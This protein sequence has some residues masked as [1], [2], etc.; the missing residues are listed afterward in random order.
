ME[1]TLTIDGRG[2]TFK[3][4]SSLIFRYQAQTGKDLLKVIM[5]L[6]KSVMTTSG[7]VTNETVLNAVEEHIE[8]SDILTIV[9]IMAKTADKSIPDPEE[10]LDSFTEFYIWDV[11]SELFPVLAQSLF[12]SEQSKKKLQAMM[13]K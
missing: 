7:E 1:K 5:P 13:K 2:V 4:S 11:V 10:W 3:A 8:L 12:A 6:L 9:W